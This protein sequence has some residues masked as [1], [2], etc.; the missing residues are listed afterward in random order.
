MAKAAPHVQVPRRVE[1]VILR[2]LEKH[3]KDRYA[4]AREL[5][6]AL[7]ADVDPQEPGLLQSL[8]G[9]FRRRR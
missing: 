4:S 6:D 3:P 1:Q 5:A 9:L 8:R 2:V 7:L